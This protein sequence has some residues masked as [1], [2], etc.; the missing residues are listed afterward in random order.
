MADSP[1]T[2][3]I[4]VITYEITSEGSKI[5]DTYELKSIRIVNSINRIPTATVVFLDGDP[6]EQDFPV[7]DSDD[8]IPGKEV[9]IKIGYDG[10]NNSVFKGIVI[11]H[12][13]VVSEHSGPQLKLEIKDKALKMT[14]GRKNAYFKEKKDS[15]VISSLISG[16]GLTAD[17]EATTIEHPML[18][19]HYSTDWDFM[20]NRADVNGKIVI[21]NAGKVSVKKPDV[22]S[23]AVLTVTYG[24]DLINFAAR[25]NTQ[26][27]LSASTSTAWDMSTQKIV[28]NTG[29]NP[30]VNS[31]GNIT[32][33]T[34]ADVLSV[35]DYGLQSTGAIDSD[36]LKTWSDA[37]LLKSWMNKIT[38]TASFQ[39]SEK[40][41]PG[42]IIEFKGVGNRFNGD[43]YISGVEH[44]FS[45][46]DWVTQVDIGLKDDWYSEKPKIQSVDTSGLLPGVN[47]LMIGKVKQ[48]DEDPDNEFRILITIPMM[49]DDSNGIWA[50][51]SNFYATSGAGT[52]FIPEIDDE[53]IVG[54][55]NNDP[56]FPI[57][58]GSLY[59]SKLKPG[60]D[61][62]GNDY[63]LTSDNYTKAFLTK[64]QNKIEFNDED[65]IIT[66]TT[67]GK[68]KIVFD[69]KD[70]SITV[71]DQ[72]EN[73]VYMS[74]DGILIQDKNS[75]K[76]EMTSSGIEINSPKDIKL[77]A[78]QNISAKATSNVD[79]EATSNVS[80][81]GLEITNT[82]NTSFKA[83]GNASA[84]LSASGQTTVKGAMVMIN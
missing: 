20:L 17:V 44:N 14:V 45:N 79:I 65:K 56:R 38:G 42:C 21:T 24:T 72:S 53:V 49:Q 11:K 55:L 27:Q 82:A 68:N 36:S 19:Q 50:R 25:L 83:S 1:I 10:T 74:T 57:I 12:E 29:A 28:Q 18:V 61:V 63:A 69:D 84:E 52:F 66:V 64:A 75:N 31:Q 51:L 76:I 3:E 23:S 40:A 80:V 58:L 26:S 39:G 13:V 46:G 81:K 77:V 71:Q 22:S 62:D 9:E 78:T 41:V 48:L 6:A 7:S 70:K 43:A 35:T 37:Q 15:D 4:G 32:S 34:L 30:S 67:P 73:K 60:K 2:D 5:S 54:F 16:A 8:L 59:S 33:S 47:G